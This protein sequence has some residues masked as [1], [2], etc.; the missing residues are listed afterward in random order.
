VKRPAFQEEAVVGG[1]YP[2]VGAEAVGEAG[3]VGTWEFCSR[4]GGR[5]LGGA[6]WFRH[7]FMSQI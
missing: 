1:A 7:Q 2:E 4:E 3:R 5:E 6:H